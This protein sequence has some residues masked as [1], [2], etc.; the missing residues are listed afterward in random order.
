[1]HSEKL[2]SVS[3]ETCYIVIILMKNLRSIIMIPK[4][5]WSISEC[6]FGTTSQNFSRQMRCRMHW[7]IVADR[8]ILLTGSSF[9]VRDLV[10]F[11]VDYYMARL[12]NWFLKTVTGKFKKIYNDIWR[13]FGAT[14]TSYK[15]GIYKYVW[16]PCWAFN[17]LAILFYP[18]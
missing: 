6:M 18:L 4:I 10:A 3:K 2:C 13:I 8:F 7:T 14:F 15:I 11:A 5:T 17:F 1:M 12:S 16:W 9:S